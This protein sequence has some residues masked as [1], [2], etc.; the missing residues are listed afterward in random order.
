MSV[1]L[2]FSISVNG[3]SV[4]CRHGILVLGL[5]LGFRV[6]VSDHVSIV[7]PLCVNISGSDDK[8]VLPPL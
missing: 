1:R 6:R 3:L 2:A 5:G 7:H 4:R 8:P